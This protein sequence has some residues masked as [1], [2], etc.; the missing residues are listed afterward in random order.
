MTQLSNETDSHLETGLAL[1]F[2]VLRKKISANW[3]KV[4]VF[5]IKISKTRTV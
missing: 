1:I 3:I 4:N 5:V 2:C